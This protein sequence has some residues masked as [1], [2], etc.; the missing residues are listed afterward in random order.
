MTSGMPSRSAPSSTRTARAS[1]SMR[2]S[3][4][5]PPISGISV[6]S[7]VLVPDD[8]A[9]AR[10]R[11]LRACGP[12][13]PGRN[14]PV[15]ALAPAVESFFTGYLTA[16]RD[17]SPHTIAS[18]RDTFRLLFTWIRQQAGTGHPTS[19]SP[20]ST[21][22]RSAASWP[23]SRTSGTTPAG[24]AASG[25]PPPLPVP[26]RGP[27]APRA[28]RAHRPGP[29]HPAAKPARKTVAWLTE[30]KPMPSWP[31]RTPGPGPAAV[32]ASDAP[33]AHQRPASI[34]GNR[35]HLG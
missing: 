9:G 15:T 20:T 5:C 14:L 35:S 33:P 23:C 1:T 11:R 26:P 18:Y 12:V 2:G 10:R 27:R 6:R 29:G 21:P 22:R 17:A 8:H 3:R 19:A 28:R 7:H 30:T 31:R 32:T 24:P 16:Q 25:S 4:S 13:L 34:R